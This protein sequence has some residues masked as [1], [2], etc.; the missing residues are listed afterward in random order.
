VGSACHGEAGRSSCADDRRAAWFVAEL[1]PTRLFTGEAGGCLT[2]V[3][4][5]P[6]AARR[7]VAD[8]GYARSAPRTRRSS[9]GRRAGS[10]LGIACSSR[11]SAVDL[12]LA[13]A[14]LA[15]RSTGA[16]VG[17]AAAFSFSASSACASTARSHFACVGPFLGRAGCTRAF[18]G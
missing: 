7:P 10:Y 2:G 8:V 6:V 4:S 11:D 13:C 16:L 5:A 3:G 12:G 17:R 14:C 9:R 1:G 15:A 18:M